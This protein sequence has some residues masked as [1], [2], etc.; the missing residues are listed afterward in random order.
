M[1]NGPKWRVFERISEQ[2][3]VMCA[4]FDDCVRYAPL[5]LHSF[6]LIA[7]RKML[8]AQQLNR[9]YHRYEEINNVQDRIRWCRHRMGL[10]QKE[11]AELIG[12]SRQDYMAYEVG[13]YDYYPK[14]VVDKLAALF[15]IPVEDLLDDYNRFLRYGQGKAIQEYREQNGLKKKQLA[16][17][18][19]LEPHTLLIWETEQKRMIK[20]SWEKYFKDIIK[21]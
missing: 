8:E 5:F 7:P 11:V 17:L 3:Y 18:L 1:Q 9:R 2:C 6:R 14:D 10:M 12:L 19:K 15:E 16:R 13:Y 20:G 4:T 21:I